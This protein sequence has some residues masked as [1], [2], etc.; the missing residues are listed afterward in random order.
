MIK[1]RNA[2]PLPPLRIGQSC[3]PW[4][5]GRGADITRIRAVVFKNIETGRGVEHFD[6]AKVIFAP[7]AA[8]TRRLAKD[9][10]AGR[11][12]LRVDRVVFHVDTATGQ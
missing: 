4:V 10:T 8:Q 3:M 5:R 6:F 7:I 12:G 1:A 2:L 11:T 9:R